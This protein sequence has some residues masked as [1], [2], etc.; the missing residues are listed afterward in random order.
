M[1]SCAKCLALCYLRACAEASTIIL[2]SLAT[3][4]RRPS[5][6]QA[7]PGGATGSDIGLPNTQNLI[8]VFA[9]TCLLYQRAVE[10]LCS[11]EL[12]N[13]VIENRLPGPITQS[14]NFPIVR[15]VA[16]R[17]QCESLPQPMGNLKF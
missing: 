11:F 5:A 17:Q 6:S 13:F 15:K 16:L 12:G 1:A 2:F 3:F 4:P 14:P 9:S 10:E 8:V 7:V